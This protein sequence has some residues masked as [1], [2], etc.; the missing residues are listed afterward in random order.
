MTAPITAP[1]TASITAPITELAN[2]YLGN[3]ATDAALAEQLHQAQ[4]S[5]QYLEV[6]LERSDRMKGR[7]HIQA[8]SGEAI[9][10]V[11]E[12]SWALTEGDV[13]QTQSGKL[14]LVRLKDQGMIVLQ[15]ASGSPAEA[16]VEDPAAAAADAAADVSL[17]ALALVHLG[18][19]LG[20][21][22]YPI[23]IQNDGIYIPVT[24]DRQ[25]IESTI[26]S[27]KI[28]GLVMR[29]EERSPLSLDVEPHR[30]EQ[31]HDHDH[32]HDLVS[33]KPHA[34][35]HSHHLTHDHHHG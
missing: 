4:H 33:P 3:I 21:H 6:A 18:H 13:L 35:N 1:V 29:Y 20:N 31:A 2:H 11:K 10:I 30:Q 15:F 26:R 34:L 28:P 14:L 19:T 5:Q 27:F 23:S 12:R 25:G 24:G 32:D 9:G 16:Q 22:H 7:I 17:H 8:L